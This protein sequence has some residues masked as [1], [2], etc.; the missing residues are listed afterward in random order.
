MNA[1][2]AWSCLIFREAVVFMEK[3]G[4]DG[5]DLDYE[6]PHAAEKAG[7]A[8]WVKELRKAFGDKYEVRKFLRVGPLAIT[9]EEGLFLYKIPLAYS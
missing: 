4:F 9:T 3:W 1:P 6:H 2:F 7:Y 8:N 5:L